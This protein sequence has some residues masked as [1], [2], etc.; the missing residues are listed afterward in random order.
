MNAPSTWVICTVLAMALAASA[1]ADTD[2]ETDSGPDLPTYVPHQVALP[3]N[4]PYLQPDGSIFIAGN[5]LMAPIFKKLNALFTKTHPGFKF[6]LLLLTSSLSLPGLTSGKSAFGP[7]GREADIQEQGAFTSRYGYPPFDIQ[8]GWDNNPSPDVFPGGKSPVSIWVNV[9][10][11]VP[12]LTMD[13]VRQIFTTGSP[14][15]DITHWGQIAGDEQPTGQEGGE[16]CWRQIHVY[17]PNQRKMPVYS[18]TRMRLGGKPWTSHAEY[19]PFPEDAVNAVAEDKFGIALT[20][21]FPQDAGWER[22]GELEHLVR[23]MPLEAGDH[24]SH[25]GLGDLYPLTI[26]L[27][28]YI[29]RP[30]GEPLEPWMKE[31]LRLALSKQGQEIVGSLTQSDGF[32]PLS[33][34]DAAHQLRKLD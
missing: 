33:A 1:W 15:G 9:N 3:T 20:G 12:V 10:N 11:P 4:R 22:R 18:T 7:T 16:W 28:L 25:G 26:G 30:P 32:I 17:L 23:I 24:V 6:K 34:E 5:D 27:H 19:L 31:Y 29:N 21:N 14:G 13:Q 8:I 2:A